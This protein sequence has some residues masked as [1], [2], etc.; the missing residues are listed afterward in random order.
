M[1]VAFGVRFNL[2]IFSD[3]HLMSYLAM[4]LEIP[5][6]CLVKLRMSINSLIDKLNEE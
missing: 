5:S 4:M 2:W 6:Y 1:I 3:M